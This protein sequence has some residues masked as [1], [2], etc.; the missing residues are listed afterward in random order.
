MTDQELMMQE[1]WRDI[2]RRPGMNVLA[3]FLTSQLG[4]ARSQL[5]NPSV[6]DSFNKVCEIRGEQRGIRKVIQYIKKEYDR[7]AMSDTPEKE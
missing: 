2:L 4:H 5:E 1:D 7:A 3:G 6:A